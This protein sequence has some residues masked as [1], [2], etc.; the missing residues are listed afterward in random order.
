MSNIYSLLP[1]VMATASARVVLELG[2]HRG[3]DTLKLRRLFPGARLYSFEPDPRN[4]HAMRQ[5]GMAAFTTLIEAAVSD[6]DGEAEFHLSSADLVG[7]PAWVTDAEYGGSSSLKRPDALTRTH[8]WCRLD[9]TAT[10]RT[11]SLDTFVRERGLRHIDLIWADVQGAEDLMIAGGRDALAMTAMLYTECSDG[12]EYQGQ[13]PLDELLRRLPG[14]W[15]VVRRFP[16]DVLLRN[17]TLLDE[18]R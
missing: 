16:Y 12:R 13:L 10:V 6:R 5:T 3:E 8:P 15:E 14:R 9:R 18:P 11:V 17:L 2:A 4:I 1:Q 7:A